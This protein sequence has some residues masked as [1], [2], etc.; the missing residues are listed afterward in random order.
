MW[1][2]DFPL[3]VW[4]MLAMSAMCKATVAYQQAMIQ[5][6]VHS[7]LFQSCSVKPQDDG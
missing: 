2:D 4:C 1:C 6:A 7:C 3:N 5:F